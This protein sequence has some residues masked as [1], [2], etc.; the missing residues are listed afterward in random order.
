[1]LPEVDQNRA[2][3]RLLVNQLHGKVPLIEK[4]P[5]SGLQPFLVVQTKESLDRHRS[6]VAGGITTAARFGF[7]GEPPEGDHTLATGSPP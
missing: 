5:V 1:M 3:F 2:H 4:N 7:G 6:G